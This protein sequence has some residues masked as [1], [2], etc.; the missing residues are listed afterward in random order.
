LGWRNY[1]GDSG[2]QKGEG[3]GGQVGQQCKMTYIVF[4]DS[5]QGFKHIRELDSNGLEE[6]IKGITMRPS[7]HFMYYI[8]KKYESNVPIVGTRFDVYKFVK[9]VAGSRVEQP[10]TDAHEYAITHNSSMAWFFSDNLFE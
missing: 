3:G 6:I 1:F 8:Y 4:Q 2:Y 10:R 7:Q 9:A 5:F